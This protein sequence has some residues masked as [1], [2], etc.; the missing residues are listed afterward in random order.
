[1]G[2][3]YSEVNMSVGTGV[4]GSKNV[5]VGG[6][7]I[8]RLTAIKHASGFGYWVIIKIKNTNEFNVFEAG[9]DGVDTVPVVSFGGAPA[10]SYGYMVGSPDGSKL[11]EA[12]RNT[13]FY[14]FG[15]QK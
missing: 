5:Y 15:K 13:G 7:S 11:A 14:L 10:T 6:P 3:F 9:C 12:Q 4:V 2:L 8:E 1:M